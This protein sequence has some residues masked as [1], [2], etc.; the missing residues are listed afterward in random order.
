MVPSKKPILLIKKQMN[1]ED[2]NSHVR[3]PTISNVIVMNLIKFPTIN[4]L[5]TLSRKIKIG[6]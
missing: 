2:N 5:I 6:I 4:P 3:Q 1:L